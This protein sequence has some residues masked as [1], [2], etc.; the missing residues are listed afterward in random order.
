M[1]LML[2]LDYACLVGL[3]FK[4]EKILPANDCYQIIK[5]ISNFFFFA[6]T[7]PIVVN[8]IEL[9]VMSWRGFNSDFYSIHCLI[10]SLKYSVI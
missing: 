4:I 10:V 1:N 3:N 2:Q 6:F 8:V 7:M 5:V 9:T